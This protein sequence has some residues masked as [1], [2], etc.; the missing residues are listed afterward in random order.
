MRALISLLTLL[1][2]TNPAWSA[3]YCDDLG[4]AIV[5]GELYIHRTQC[6]EV[7]EPAPNDP[8]LLPL[9]ETLA[10]A[11]EVARCKLTS[12][13]YKTFY[14][15]LDYSGDPDET[16]VPVTADDGSEETRR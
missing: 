2:L 7:Y 8:C 15:T 9:S 1:V 13:D 3:P 12:E 4:K 14:A 10:D 5:D 11:Q 16:G 6:T